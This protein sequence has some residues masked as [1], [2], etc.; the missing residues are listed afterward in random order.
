MGPTARTVDG[1]GKCEMRAISSGVRAM[2]RGEEGAGL[3]GEVGRGSEGGL[4]SADWS[5]RFP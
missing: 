5:C 1:V 3:A 2:R 4:K